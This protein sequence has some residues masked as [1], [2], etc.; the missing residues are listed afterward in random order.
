M[1]RNRRSGWTSSGSAADQRDSQYAMGAARQ[2]PFGGYQ[3]T[4]N[5]FGD[6]EA[7]ESDL[8]LPDL[9]ESD[10]EPSLPQVKA[11]PEQQLQDEESFMQ[12]VRDLVENA[13]RERI[14]ILERKDLVPH[15]LPTGF[16][17]RG[18]A[19]SKAVRK[20]LEKLNKHLEK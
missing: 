5:L 15:E 11:S 16:M 12:K 18:P 19:F 14:P 20:D 8:D 4:P 6:R 3:A 7:G 1:E 2:R 17:L 9:Y 13:V 10:E